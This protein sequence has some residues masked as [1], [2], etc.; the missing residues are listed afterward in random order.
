MNSFL[1]L[2]PRFRPSDFR[3]RICFGF[4]IS[5]F[6]FNSSHALNLLP[7]LALSLSPL[8]AHADGGIVRARQTQGAFTVTVFSPAEIS[9]AKPTDLTLL[10]QHRDTGDVIM[11]AIVDMTLVP[12]ANAHIRP[13]DPFCSPL[14]PIPAYVLAGGPSLAAT[15]PATRARAANKL[16]Y[17]L[18]IILHAPGTWQL[19]AT[20]REGADT[21]Y[22]TCPIP[23]GVPAARLGILW[24]SLALP[25]VAILLFSLNQWL[26][27]RSTSTVPDL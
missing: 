14:N 3:F 13:G 19:Q 9:A 24:P 26:R 1:R 17:G 25:P 11:D 7:C 16:L 21:A 20:V 23:V 4:R 6:G 2:R 18:S 27:R 10:V 5:D 22:I 15:F 12:P 8:L